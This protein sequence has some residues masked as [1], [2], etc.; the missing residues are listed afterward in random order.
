ML[1]FPLRAVSKGKCNMNDQQ[2][3]EIMLELVKQLAK[4]EARAIELMK[5]NEILK[6]EIFLLSRK[7]E[8][9]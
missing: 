5:Q 7:V 6:K 4:A 9:N 3:R 8:K 1:V 2:L